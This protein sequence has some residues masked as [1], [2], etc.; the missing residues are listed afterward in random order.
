LW[1]SFIKRRLS[2]NYPGIK[3]VGIRPSDDDR[4]KAFSETQTLM[5]VY[6]RLSV[7][8]VISAPAV[9]GA[10]EAIKQSGSKTVHVVGLSLPNLCKPYVHS[11]EVEAVVLWKTGDLGYLAVT[12]PAALV[13]GT[14]P[15]DKKFFPAGK[16]GP[17]RIEASE[18][19]LGKPFIFRKN[20][21][22]HFNF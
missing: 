13:R 2:D 1:I 20:N 12:A 6:P 10:G 11:G 22:D 21:I 8:V 16:L 19:I 7:I 9:P 14:F 4:D 15:K 3:L 5:K 17:L 18:V